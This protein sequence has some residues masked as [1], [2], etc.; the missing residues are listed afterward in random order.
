MM[1]AGPEELTK[2]NFAIGSN[3]FLSEA[4]KKFI[5]KLYPKK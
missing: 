4:D 5:A 1:Y 3:D 2:G